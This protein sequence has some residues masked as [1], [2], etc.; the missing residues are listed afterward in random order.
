MDEILKNTFDA[1]DS[2]DLKRIAQQIVADVAAGADLDS[3][4]TQTQYAL[5]LSFE[6]TNKVAALMRAADE[7]PTTPPAAPKEEK[8]GYD[9]VGQIMAY[10]AGELDEQQTIELFQALVDSGLAWSLQGRY[11]RMANELIGQGLVFEQRA[12]KSSV[13]EEDE[14]EN[15]PCAKCGRK[16]LPLHVDGM[17]PNCSPKSTDELVRGELAVE[18]GLRSTV[19]KLR[20][21]L[22]KADA[23]DLDGL[24][25]LLT[26]ID[27]V[28][29]QLEQKSK[30]KE[31]RKKKK[32]S[33]HP[34]GEA[35]SERDEHE[36]QETASEEEAEHEE[37]DS[38]EREVHADHWQS[39]GREDISVPQ[40]CEQCQSVFF[41][42]P[43]AP[44]AQ[45]LCPMCR[46]VPV[47]A[48]L[49]TADNPMSSE[50][51][52]SAPAPEAAPAQDDPTA[53]LM[54]QHAI[55]YAQFE[56]ELK[57]AQEKLARVM[58]VEELKAQLAAEKPMLLQQLQEMPD[59]MVLLMSEG[60]KWKAMGVFPEPS[61]NK[62]AVIKRFLTRLV[63]LDK[64]GI[65]WAKQANNMLKGLMQ[66][67]EYHTPIAPHLKVTPTPQ[68]DIDLPHLPVPDPSFQ[69]PRVPGEKSAF[70]WTFADVEDMETRQQQQSE[71][72]LEMAGEQLP[73]VLENLEE[74]MTSFLDM[75][76]IMDSELATGLA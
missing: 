74:I 1:S 22:N 70:L 57:E 42:A 56:V 23:E 37:S 39:E 67:P 72:Q 18:A 7:P 63:E 16:D 62:A 48:V 5:G 21:Q 55:A 64:Q 38:E 15:V 29:K 17:C 34:A 46:G 58:G 61:V 25:K 32:E 54:A 53:E 11:G 45:A 27:G 12:S 76:D 69:R 28:E 43:V 2:H 8:A 33:A 68:K 9:Q 50:G 52:T 4:L 60:E 26:A 49:K 71:K 14:P 41:G 19:R 59:K 35:L 66:A 40:K 13:E 47:E 24:N 75:F 20:Q 30:A 10:E 36:A 65:E 73:S 3:A 6:E 44:S 51:P 31:E